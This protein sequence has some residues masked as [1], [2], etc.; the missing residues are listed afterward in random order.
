MQE[1]VEIEDWIVL[2]LRENGGRGHDPL[3]GEVG[4]WPPLFAKYPP[5]SRPFRLALQVLGGG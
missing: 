1:V 2:A 3:G 5:E 4:P